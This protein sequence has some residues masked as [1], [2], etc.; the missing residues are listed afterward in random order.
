MK[1]DLKPVYKRQGGMSCGNGFCNSG[2]GK[3]V[4]VRSAQGTGGPN[5]QDITTFFGEGG[6][7]R[8]GFFS[9]E[10]RQCSGSQL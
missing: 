5:L 3:A 2:V 7:V 8:I 1:H 10:R 6:D 4:T 9:Y